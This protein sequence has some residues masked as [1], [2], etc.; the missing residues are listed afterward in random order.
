V[1]NSTASKIMENI[2]FAEYVSKLNDDFYV[3]EEVVKIYLK[4]YVL[5]AQVSPLSLSIFTLTRI[6]TGVLLHY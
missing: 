2:L 5:K 6:L 1:K 4:I 3:V